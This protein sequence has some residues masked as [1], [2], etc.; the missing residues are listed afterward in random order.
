MAGLRG[1]LLSRRHSRSGKQSEG[2]TSEWTCSISSPTF[3]PLLMLTLPP[4][5]SA[6]LEHPKTSGERR[7][8]TEG[9]GGLRWLVVIP[10][11]V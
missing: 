3:F 2:L 7:R 8:E 9:G 6:G 11:Q 4:F 1:E 5:F 10:E